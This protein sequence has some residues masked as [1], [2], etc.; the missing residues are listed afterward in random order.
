MLIMAVGDLDVDYQDRSY[1]HYSKLFEDYDQQTKTKLKD[2][3]QR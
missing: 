2:R 1:C 3:I